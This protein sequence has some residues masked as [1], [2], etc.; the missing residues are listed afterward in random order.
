MD[1]AVESRCSRA[2]MAISKASRARSDRSDV[3]TCQPTMNRLKTSMH[4]GDV[5]EADVGLHVGQ[6]RHP[7]PVRAI[8]DEASFDEV[9]RTILCLVGDGG[10]SPLPATTH[11]THPQITHE[12]LDGAAGHRGA[13]PVE[14]G[15]DLVGPID[16][17]GSRRAPGRSRPSRPRRAVVGRRCGRDLRRVVG[18]GS[19]LQHLADRLDSPPQPVGTAA[20]PMG[21]DEAHYFFG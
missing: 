4:E 1:E 10:S 7:E 11:T 19:E 20:V 16:A 2:W 8:G 21:V 14:L 12:A 9:G 18:G 6:V 13:L 5:D 15:P 17:S 3:E